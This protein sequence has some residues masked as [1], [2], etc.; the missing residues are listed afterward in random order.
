MKKN[1][2][3]SKHFNIFQYLAVVYVVFLASCNVD[4][5]SNLSDDSQIKVAYNSP[6]QNTVEYS[7]DVVDLKQRC[8]PISAER[9][10]H[11]NYSLTISEFNFDEFISNLAEPTLECFLHSLHIGQKDVFTLM[12]FSP[13]LQSANYRF[14]RLHRYALLERDPILYRDSQ[15]QRHPR[16]NRHPR[17]D[18]HRDFT[19]VY[20]LTNI[21]DFTALDIKDRPF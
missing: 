16:L 19:Y 6:H 18:T 3:N 17:L 13:S 1:I 7:P 8:Q 12:H 2:L 14:P 10:N 5:Q 4:P 11:L 15:L 21:R 9:Y 20:D